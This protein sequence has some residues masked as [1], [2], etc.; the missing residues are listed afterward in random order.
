[1]KSVIKMTSTQTYRGSNRVMRTNLLLFTI[2]SIYFIVHRY[3]SIRPCMSKPIMMIKLNAILI[4]LK[5]FT[6]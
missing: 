4:Y 3:F 2:Y 5:L 6:L 1:M